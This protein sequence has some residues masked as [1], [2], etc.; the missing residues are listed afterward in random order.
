M[1]GREWLDPRDQK[2]WMVSAQGVPRK[3]AF[4]CMDTL[5]SYSTVV[6]SF[7]AVPKIAESELVA[8]LDRARRA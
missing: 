6:D 5:E 8:L 1:T 3:V 7:A 2:R 4:R